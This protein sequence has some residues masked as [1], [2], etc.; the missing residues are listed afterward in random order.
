MAQDKSRTIPVFTYETT[1]DALRRVT[2]KEGTYE[3][4]EQLANKTRK[5]LPIFV[6]VSTH[7]PTK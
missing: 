2:W 4:N 7:Y 3:D 5:P 1:D 6:E